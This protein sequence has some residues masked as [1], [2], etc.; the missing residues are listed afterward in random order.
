MCV[1]LAHSATTQTKAG[2]FRPSAAWERNDAIREISRPWLHDLIPNDLHLF[3]S[4]HANSGFL[5]NRKTMPREKTNGKKENKEKKHTIKPIV[6]VIP[7]NWKQDEGE[8]GKESFLPFSSFPLSPI[9]PSLLPLAIPPTQRLGNRSWIA[10]KTIGRPTYTAGVISDLG[11]I[12][13]VIFDTI[14]RTPEN[15]EG[16][17]NILCCYADTNHLQN[18]LE[19]PQGHDLQQSIEGNCVFSSK[20]ILTRRC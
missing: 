4:M 5:N 10:I 3:Q 15:M 13:L 14:Y 6:V 16:Y 17:P 11:S 12:T 19:Y 1:Y 18:H 8:R 7:H 20:N 9:R 2:V